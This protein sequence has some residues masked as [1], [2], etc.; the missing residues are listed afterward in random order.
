MNHRAFVAF[1]L[2]AFC[3]P[4]LL[5]AQTFESDRIAERRVPLRLYF[6]APQL[7]PGESLTA[8]GHPPFLPNPRSKKFKR[9]QKWGMVGLIAGAS[10]GII[11]GFARVMSD[12]NKG[13]L[14]A[15][16]AYLVVLTA[17]TTL[18]MI[19]GAIAGIV[20]FIIFEYWKPESA[21][22]QGTNED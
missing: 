6:T 7:L 3:F 4:S 2:S 12:E 8:D 13:G 10:A 1:V 18:G 15:A 20:G 14:S 21:F 17:Y 22:D 11:A 19:G 5:S 9:F 16:P